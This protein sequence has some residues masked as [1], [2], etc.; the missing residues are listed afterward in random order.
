MPCTAM[1]CGVP[2]QDTDCVF[3]LR[4]AVQPSAKNLGDEG[5]FAPN[6]KSPH[7]TLT[8]IERA[9]EAAGFK[10]GADVFLALVRRVASLR[11]AAPS[12]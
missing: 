6:L 10:V 11:H 12:C 1:R 2:A 4:C 9:I 3:A 8:Y 7:E 5:G